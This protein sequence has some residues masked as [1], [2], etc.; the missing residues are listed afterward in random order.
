MVHQENNMKDKTFPPSLAIFLAELDKRMKMDNQK[1]EATKSEGM[2]FDSEKPDMDLV[3][4]DFSNALVEVAKVGTFGAKKYER[5][6]WL[7]VQ[8]G[9][10]R[11]SSALLRH[12]FDSKRGPAIDS[13]SNLLHLSH[14]AWNAL[15]ILELELR[16]AKT[17][18]CRKELLDDYE[19]NTE[20]KYEI[21]KGS[22]AHT[23]L[24]I[25]K[26]K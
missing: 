15:A 14:L 20:H 16:K 21:N 12:F 3:L 17:V 26:E 7:R 1:L 9:Q 8:G 13:D 11:Y 6:N 19:D 2:K 22:P 24:V 4:G 18:D 10:E 5:S 25:S 23:F